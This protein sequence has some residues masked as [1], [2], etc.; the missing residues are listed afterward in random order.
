M[1]K[2]CK[3]CGKNFQQHPQVTNQ[4]YCSEPECQRERRR[5]WRQEKRRTDPDYRENQSRIN[6]DW[7]ANN[8]EYWSQYRDANPS[9]VERNRTQQQRRNQKLRNVPIGKLYVSA[10]AFPFA[11]GLYRIELVS[12]DGIVKMDSW[13]VEIVV[14]PMNHAGV[15]ADCKERT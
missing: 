5:R 15:V 10:P 8:P 1:S 4:T 3:A 9:Y 11:S 12:G 7:L 14:L 6:K 2:R 13:T